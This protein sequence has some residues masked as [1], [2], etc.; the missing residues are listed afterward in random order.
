MKVVELTGHDD[1]RRAWPVMR[2][3]RD[4]LDEERWIELAD[5][6][7][8]DGYRLLSL[9]GDDG[10]I[11]ALA[12]FRVATNLYYGKHVW[13][14]DLVTTGGSTSKGH[15]RLLLGAV[16]DVA[17]AEGCELVALSSGLQRTDAHRFYEEAMAYDKVSYCFTK[18]VG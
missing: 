15:G 3:L 17:A 10:A 13:V 7:V 9:Q 1:F 4:H 2:E 6:M 16:E 11:E 14:Y 18:P 5:V 8:L 12:G